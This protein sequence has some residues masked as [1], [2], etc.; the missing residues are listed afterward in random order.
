MSTLDQ[1]RGIAIPLQAPPVS[2]E[3]PGE[4]QDVAPAYEAQGVWRLAVNVFVQHRLAVIGLGIVI[5]MTLFC[6]IGPLIYHTDQTTVNLN[7]EELAPGAGHWLGTD[8]YGFDVIGRLMIGG[9]TSLEIGIAAALIATIFGVVWGAVAGFFGGWIDALLMRFVDVMLAI[10][11]LFLLLFLAV[12]FPRTVPILILVVAVTAWLIPARLVRAEALTL[13]TRD[14]VQAVTM[15]GGGGFR[16]VMR[17]I[18]PNSIGTIMVNATFQVADA[19]L[20]VAAINFLGL[21]IAPPATNWGAMLSG[22]VGFVYDGWWWLIYPAG[23]AIVLTV[24]A[25]NF[26]GD[27]LRDAL[28]VRLQKR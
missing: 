8:E 27:A 5:F 11:S 19:I 26:I 3:K 24:V 17:H 6:F 7:N 12:A 25:F 1:P 23:I 4:V 18:I 22:G 21:G 16:I 10:P 13:R 2:Q 9:Q 28:E 14:Y 20:L 15:M